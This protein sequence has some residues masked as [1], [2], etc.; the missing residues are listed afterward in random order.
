MDYSRYHYER[1]KKERDNKRK[2][3]TTHLKQI[4]LSPNINKHDLAIKFKKIKVFLEEGHKVRINMLFKGRQQLHKEIGTGIMDAIIGQ[5]EG[6][7]TCQEAPKYEGRF[8]S[9][10]MVPGNTKMVENV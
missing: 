7:A 3:K 9:V 5:L 4:R 8:M 10:T 6:V 2:A 1:K